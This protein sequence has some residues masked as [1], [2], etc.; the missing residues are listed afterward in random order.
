MSSGLSTRGKQVQNLPRARGKKTLNPLPDNK[1]LDVSKLQAFADDN[2]SVA[3]KM[4]SY[5]LIGQKTLWEKEQF[6]IFLRCFQKPSFLESLKPRSL[7]C[8]ESE[9]YKFFSY[10][11]TENSRHSKVKS[12]LCLTDFAL[13]WFMTD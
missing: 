7:E 11:R 5:S 8:E 1:I 6:F 10:S 3:Q 12:V 13:F 4:C 9:I 2:F